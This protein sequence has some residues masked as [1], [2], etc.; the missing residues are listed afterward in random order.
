MQT[1]RSLALSQTYIGKRSLRGEVVADGTWEPLVDE[2]LFWTVARVLGDSDRSTV[3]PARGV[4]LLTHIARASA[5]ARWAF[6]GS[7][8]PR[9]PGAA[10]CSTTCASATGARR[11]RGC[12]G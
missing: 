2:E 4:W 3:R 10:A 12:A 6:T 11:P 9:G 5:A 8:G 7:S 1:L